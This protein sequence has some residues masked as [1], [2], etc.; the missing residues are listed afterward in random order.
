LVDAPSSMHEMLE[1]VE[2]IVASRLVQE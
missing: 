1:G 2:Q